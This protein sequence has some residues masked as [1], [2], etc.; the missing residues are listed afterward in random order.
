MT[1][2]S[3]APAVLAAAAALSLA[4]ATGC[5]NPGEAGNRD[6]GNGEVPVNVRSLEVG[7]TTMREYLTVSGPLRP[8]RGADVS[9]EEGGVVVSIPKSKGE[10][11]EEG[12][13]L[14]ALDRDL[15]AAEMRSAEADRDL[16]EYNGTR[17]KSLFEANQVSRE[18][19][20][21][22]ETEL[23]RADAAWDIARIR[24]E[25]AAVKA[26]FDGLLADRYVEEGELLV[27]GTRVARVV[28]PGVL[29]VVASVSEREVRRV[30]P[31]AAAAVTV[32]GVPGTKEAHVHWVSFEADP[33]SGKFQVEVRVANESG[34]LRPGVVARAQILKDVHE[35]VVV[36][37]RDAVVLRAEGPTVFV[38]DED[39]ARARPV[40]LGADQGLMTVVE[41]GLRGGERIVV[42]GQR[43]LQ[44]G[45]LV[46]VREEATAPDGS[47]DGDPD[48]VRAAEAFSPPATVG[49][50]GGE[51]R[52]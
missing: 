49:D 50:G 20:V 30:Q 13:V 17:I 45:S 22:A 21:R 47:A 51:T 5:G 42:R 36:I 16:R 4:A 32:E 2:G 29:K 52:P 25:R 39:R 24:W 38:L 19:L 34:D 48:E 27:P 7:R 46:T 43:E 10:Y 37:P 40:T 15:L 26:P 14:V 23:A 44:N 31:G 9:T 8:F 11:V 33:M 1:Q 18:E 6:P 3:A 12:E 41:E 35:D 28:D